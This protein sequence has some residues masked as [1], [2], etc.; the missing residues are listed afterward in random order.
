MKQIMHLS[1]KSTL[2]TDKVKDIIASR[3]DGD[4]VDYWRLDSNWKIEGREAVTKN[5]QR[6]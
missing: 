6:N 5:I 1:L 3:G 4:I 2:D